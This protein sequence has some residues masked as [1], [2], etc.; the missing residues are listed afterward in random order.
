MD[1]F[2]IDIYRSENEGT[3][4]NFETLDDFGSGKLI[5]MLFSLLEITSY[6]ISTKSFFSYLEG[7]LA[8]KIFYKDP[9]VD[10]D[11]L[12]SLSKELLLEGQDNVYIIWDVNSRVDSI[13][14]AE[15][16]NNWDYIWYDVSD[17]AIVL[18]FPISKRIVFI[19]DHGYV[20]Y[21]VVS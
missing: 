16:I 6:E 12:Y 1:K 3:I 5:G 4:F 9:G 14:L 18:F 11:L 15:L 10:K 19:T 20:S 21:K 2:K 7:K 17:E 13:K 8:D